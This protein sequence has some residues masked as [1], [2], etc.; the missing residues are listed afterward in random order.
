MLN[1][2]MIKVDETWKLILAIH[3]GSCQMSLFS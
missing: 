3:L 2:G 1:V